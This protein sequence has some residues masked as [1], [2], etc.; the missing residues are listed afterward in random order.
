MITSLYRPTPAQRAAHD[1]L[2]R[3]HDRDVDGR[4]ELGIALPPD[5][6]AVCAALRDLDRAV[7]FPEADD[8]SLPPGE[9]TRR[10][11]WHHRAD[12]APLC[13]ADLFAGSDL[14]DHLIRAAVW[15]LAP[16]GP[17]Q[18]VERIVDR[19]IGSGTRGPVPRG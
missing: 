17:A 3:L 5:H 13:Q 2:R 18:M 19:H 10:W 11:W 15:R 4:R 9:G 8:E 16:E 1:L 14:A 7:G 6:A 12:L